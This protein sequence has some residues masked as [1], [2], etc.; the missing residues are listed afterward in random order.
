MAISLANRL[1]SLGAVT[2]SRVIDHYPEEIEVTR[3][4]RAHAPQIVF[5]SVGSVSAA[6]ST[7]ELLERGA[8]GIQVVAVHENLD[9]AVMLEV[10]RVGIREFI[11]T[12]FEEANVRD[13]L[14]RAADNLKKKPVGIQSSD[15]VFSFLPSKPGVGT[16][17]LALNI[18]VALSHVDSTPTLL[19]DFDLNC[20]LMQF[21]LKLEGTQNI[22]D[23]AERSEEL[24]EQLWPQ[25]VTGIGSMDVLHAGKLDPQRR[26]EP[27]Q[28]RN[29]LEFARRNY[30]VIC[31]DLSGNLERYSIEIMSESK[32]IFLVCTQELPSLHLA[33]EKVQFLEHLDLGDRIK[34]LINRAHKRTLISAAEIEQL[35]GRPVYEAFP[36]DYSGVHKAL[37]EG[38]PIQANTDLGKHC[39]EI[40][41]KLLDRETLKTQNSSRFVQYFTLSP[42]R[43]SFGKNH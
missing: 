28:I 15:L 4:L 5:L 21:M 35:L 11:A 10:M 18:A 37:S 34:I 22:M 42:A 2:V 40:A 29:L 3:A 33:R 39:A 43:Y 38:R 7:Y 8:P 19:A 12:P 31:A 16:T 17:T 1:C 27:L 13:V 36:N 32:A 14:L 26:I 41:A 6:A 30:H 9:P 25:L 23:A 20:G 24:D